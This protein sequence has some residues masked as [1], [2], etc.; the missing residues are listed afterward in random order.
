VPGSLAPPNPP[1]ATLSAGRRLLLSAIA[2]A[3][4]Y[5]NA[6]VAL[7][8]PQLLDLGLYVPHPGFVRHAFELTSMFS[9]YSPKN[10]DFAIYGKRTQAGRAEDRGHW[11][12][13]PLREHLP[14]RLSI[15]TMQLY[16]SLPARIDGDEGRKRAWSVFARKIRANHERL[17]PD[18]P[19]AEIRLDA[20]QWPTDPRGFRAGL[21][22]SSTVNRMWFIE[23]PE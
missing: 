12:E 4:L 13:L 18:Q 8:P 7:Q 6:M 22:P 19:V 3:L 15:T 23:S 20:F 21:S 14:R 1:P 2:L 9:S 16:A 5:G 11:I 10:E 17:H